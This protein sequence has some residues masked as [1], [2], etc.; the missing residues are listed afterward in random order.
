[1]HDDVDDSEGMVKVTQ[2]INDMY[3]VKSYL[4]KP[5][6]LI[7]IYCFQSMCMKHVSFCNK[8]IELDIIVTSVI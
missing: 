2:T 1:M 3:K 4:K 8:N 7:L 6:I 5:Y